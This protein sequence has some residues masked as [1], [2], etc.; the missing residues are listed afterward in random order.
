MKIKLKVCGFF[1]KG[2]KIRRISGLD[3]AGKTL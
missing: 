3:P 1:G 2:I